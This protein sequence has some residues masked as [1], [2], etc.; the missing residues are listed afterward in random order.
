MHASVRV[1][2]VAPVEYALAA[3]DIRR[4]LLWLIGDNDEDVAVTRHD[5][6]TLTL[7]AA[8]AAAAADLLQPCSSAFKHP[9]IQC[10][11]PSVEAER[12]LPNK[13]HGRAVA[14]RLTN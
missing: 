13:L 4:E 9:T 6:N 1:H 7:S 8:A 10:Q 2:H 5:T 12:H 11:Q 14:K 3:A